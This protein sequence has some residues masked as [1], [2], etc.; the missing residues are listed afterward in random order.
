MDAIKKYLHTYA[1]KRLFLATRSDLKSDYVLVIPAYNEC[2]DFIERLQELKKITASLLV[3]VIVNAPENAPESALKNNENL[4]KQLSVIGKENQISA[5]ALLYCDGEF[6][7]L[8]AGSYSLSPRMGVGLARKIGADFALQLIDENIITTPIIFCTDA[9]ARLPQDYFTRAAALKNSFAAA[10]YPFLHEKADDARQEQAIRL[11][12]QKMDR[13]VQGL[14]QAL[15][16]YAYHTIGSTIALSAKHYA[17][18]RG[19]PSLPAGED[20]YILNKLR[21]LGPIVSLSGSPL[22][23]S[24]RVSDRVIF[25]T[26]PALDKILKNNDPKE[27]AI[28][29]DE[30]VFEYLKEMLLAAEMQIKE[31]TTKLVF[32]GKIGEAFQAIDKGKIEKTLSSRRSIDDRLKALHDYLD[33]FKTIKFIHYLRDNY[34]PMRSFYGLST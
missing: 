33:A 17:K 34:F 31:G 26:G 24:S 4:I 18:V 13:Y 30:R 14:S 7:L 19:F 8:I 20:F 21:K 3:I 2:E 12:E 32:A 29:Y 11:Y 15:S 28:F 9:D 22:L 6:K 16:P 10:V 25:G 23:L 1:D 5:E 27:A